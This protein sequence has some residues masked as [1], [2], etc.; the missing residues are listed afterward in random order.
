VSDWVILRDLLSDLL[1]VLI[2]KPWLGWLPVTLMAYVWQE[3]D[4]PWWLRFDES[5]SDEPSEWM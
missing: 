5:M 1:R 2:R 3:D 4:P